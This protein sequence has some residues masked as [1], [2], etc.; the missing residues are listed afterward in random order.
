MPRRLLCR[1][2]FFALCVAPTVC[3]ASWVVGRSLP[4]VAATRLAELSELLGVEVRCESLQTPR[5][6]AVRLIGVTVCDR[7]LGGVLATCDRIDAGLRG[8]EVVAKLGEVRLVDGGTRDVGRAMDGLLRDDGLRAAR[9]SI[10]R[11]AIGQSDPPRW[12]GMLATLTPADGDRGGELVLQA[13]DAE[14]IA[15]RNRQIEPPTT[16]VAITTGATGVPVAMLPGVCEALGDKA[17]LAGQATLTVSELE[18]A[19]QLSGEL[20][21]ISPAEL[22]GRPAGELQLE[23]DATAEVELLAWTGNRLDELRAELQTGPGA[24]DQQLI[25]AAYNALGCRAGDPLFA[26][27]DPTG[28]SPIRFDVLRAAVRLDSGGLRVGAARDEPLLTRGGEG[29]LYPPAEARLPV[30]AVL[31]FVAP[32][33]APVR[34]TGPMV[35]PVA[36]RLPRPADAAG[37]HYRTQR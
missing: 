20:R 26:E 22:T 16:R 23:G 33:D 36:D 15:I 31:H 1:L 21:G 4:G 13:G 19:G 3:V 11:V 30:V 25:Y 37:P 35:E 27:W 24:A 17:T 12:L 2:L 8:G 9:V 10:D 29:L 14:L 5:P 28:G 6:G 18:V 7:E 32:V 34:P